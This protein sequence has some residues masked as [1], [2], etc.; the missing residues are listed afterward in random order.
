MKLMAILALFSILNTGFSQE[1]AHNKWLMKPIR[2]Q[3]VDYKQANVILSEN[4]NQLYRLI[5]DYRAANGKPSIPLSKALTFVA[6]TH[7]G[8]LMDNYSVSNRCNLNS[9]SGKGNWSSCC[10]TKNHKKAACMWNKPRE[11]TTYAGDGFEI[12]Y[13]RLTPTP[14]KAL[15]KWK[16]NPLN[17]QVVLNNGEWTEV[18]WNAIGI[19]I[20][21][22]YAVVWFGKVID[23]DG[24]PNVAL[25]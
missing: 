9:W 16:K 6:Q 3:F 4:E 23:K 2:Y 24:E 20:Y 13:T 7:A 10:Y 25:P 18:T 14:R 1:T 19:G 12:A 15:E 5:M 22:D 17:D 21:G 11:L 8:D